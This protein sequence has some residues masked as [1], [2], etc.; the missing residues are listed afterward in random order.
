MSVR[1]NRWCWG[2]FGGLISLFTNTNAAVKVI[3]L[4]LRVAA[5]KYASYLSAENRSNVSLSA[6]L[7]LVRKNAERFVNKTSWGFSLGI[8]ELLF[9]LLFAD[10]RS[11]RF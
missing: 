6:S 9:A 7:L 3:L 8:E 2:Y 10:F 11:V 5:I 1:I 4:I